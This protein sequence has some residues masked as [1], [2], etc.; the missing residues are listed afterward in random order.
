[1]NADDRAFDLLMAV[2]DHTDSTGLRR[3]TRLVERAMD[4]LLAET[5]RMTVAR[6]DRCDA[7]QVVGNAEILAPHER[8]PPEAGAQEIDL[9]RAAPFRRHVHS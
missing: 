2:A 6:E 1:M 9:V 7:Q 4:A 3:T 5:G 8:F